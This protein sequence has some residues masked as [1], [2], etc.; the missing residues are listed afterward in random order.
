MYIKQLK[1]FDFRAFKGEH[2]F[3]LG[4]NINCISGHNGIGKST[5]LA[6]LSNCGELK[7]KDGSQLNGEAFQGEYS[8]LIK[9][10]RKYDKT[11]KVCEFIFEDLSENHDST[12]PFVKELKFR[13]TFQ[14]VKSTKSRF[15]KSPDKKEL[16]I[17]EKTEELVERYRLLPM[18]QSDRKTE[19]K[20]NWPTLYLGLSR[21]Y[22]IG[23]GDS[24]SGGKL[25]E[26]IRTEMQEVHRDILSSKDNYQNISKVSM[27]DVSRKNGMGIE[28]DTYSFLAN[29]SGQDNLGQILLAVF[30]F[31]NLK[32]NYSLYSGGILLIDEIDSTLHPAAQFKLLNFLKKKSKELDLQIVFTTHSNTLLEYITFLQSK[33]NDNAITNNYIYNSRGKVETKFNPSMTFINNNLT[34]TFSGN[35]IQK[36]VTVITE[37]RIGRWFLKKILR[38]NESDIYDKLEFSDT[39][40]G[41]TEIIKLIRNDYSLFSKILIFLDPDISNK[42]NDKQLK[43]ALN[44]TAYFNKINKANGNIFYLPYGENIETLFWTY[45]ENLDIDHNFYYDRRIEELAISSDIIKNEGP[46][47]DKYN[48][49]S[50]ELT[51]RKKWFEDNKFICDILFEYWSKD[52]QESLKSFYNNFRTAFYQ[53]YNQK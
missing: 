17:K 34:E 41:W 13:A 28:T 8:H 31:E 51:K 52:N 35:S 29:S 37:D 23:E 39:Q 12:N 45:L 18:I 2:I 4:P 48:Q 30:S 9:G 19:K 50:N 32:K 46:N 53:I 5:I 14:N 25:P 24:L 42:D 1:I 10:D 26:T 27:K 44:G 33:S 43:D 16:Y 21:L 7:K 47:S 22:P 38:L 49:Y 11:G 6:L 40:I 3:E 20:L 36:K 15:V